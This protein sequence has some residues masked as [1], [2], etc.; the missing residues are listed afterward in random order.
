MSRYW[1]IYYDATVC[2]CVCACCW[3]KRRPLFIW[4]HL[5]RKFPHPSNLQSTE[6]RL[7]NLF[8]HVFLCFRVS[9]T[10]HTHSSLKFLRTPVL[11]WHPCGPCCMILTWSGSALKLFGNVAKVYDHKML[12]SLFGSNTHT[13]THPLIPRMSSRCR[14]LCVHDVL[15]LRQTD[16]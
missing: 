2:M 7:S 11:F 6:V 8:F 16:K 15:Y 1:Y 3:N 9:H 12:R 5:W 10:S 13:H 14:S 4:S